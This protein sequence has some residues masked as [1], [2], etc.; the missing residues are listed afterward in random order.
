MLHTTGRDF[1]IP[2]SYNNNKLKNNDMDFACTHCNKKTHAIM[3]IVDGHMVH[4][5][6]LEDYVKKNNLENE[7]D[8]EVE[9]V[10]LEE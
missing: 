9:E 3:T 10:I 6:C 2:R 5:S 4:L 7:S 1:K 8:T